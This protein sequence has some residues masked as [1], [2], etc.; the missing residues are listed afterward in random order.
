MICQCLA[1]QLLFASAFG[2]GK[3]LICSPLTNH[4]NYSVRRH[5]TV[6][7]T[8]CISPVHLW[9]NSMKY[10]PIQARR[11]IWKRVK[12]CFDSVI[13]SREMNEILKNTHIFV[14]VLCMSRCDAVRQWDEGA[15]QKAYKWANYFEE[16]TETKFSR[17]FLW[18]FLNLHCI[19]RGFYI[20]I[21]A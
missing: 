4:D 11:H 3:W 20:L 12:S 5:N 8:E 9:L 10:I 1:D 13:S 15:F 7:Y 14:D 17:A 2:S 16:V 19:G 21:R 6:H 18:I